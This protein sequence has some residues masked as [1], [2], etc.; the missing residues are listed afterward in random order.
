MPKRTDSNQKE[1]VAGLRKVGVIVTDLH[2]VGKGCPDILCSWRSRWLP[3]EI[4]SLGGKLSPD[5]VEWHNRQRAICPVVFS[6]NEAF[7]ALGIE[8]GSNLATSRKE[9]LKELKTFDKPRD[10]DKS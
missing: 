2:A 4:K 10:K 7:V 6:L 3:M 1:I 8:T 9:F 5:E